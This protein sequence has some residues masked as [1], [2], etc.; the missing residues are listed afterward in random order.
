MSIILPDSIKTAL[1]I[2]SEGGFEAYTVGGAVRD[3]LLGTAP[4]DWDITTSALPEDIRRLFSGYRQLLF[5]M[6]H[7]TVSV[8]IDTSPI[9]ITTYRLDGDYS[10]SRH[11][12]C[13]VFTDKLS[14]DVSRRDFTVNALC[15]DFNGEIRDEAGGLADIKNRII[16]TVGNPDKRFSEDALRILRGMRFSSVLGFGIE[17]K[18]ARS[19]HINRHLLKD[20]SAERVYSELIKLICGKDALRVLLEYGDVLA[21]VIPDIEPAIGFEQHGKKHC[22]NVWEHICHTVDNIE[23]DS[24]LRLTMLLHDLGKVPTAAIDENGSSTFK[25]HAAVGAQIAEKALREL[26]AQTKTIKAVTKLIAAHDFEIPQTLPAVRHML[27]DVGEEDLRR[28]LLIK[29]ADRGALSPEYRDVSAQCAAARE[30]IDRVISQKLCFSL[31]T[32]ALKGNHL[33]ELSIPED[34]I[35]KALDMLLDAVIDEKCENTKK[36]LCEYLKLNIEPIEY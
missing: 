16:R 26:R 29:T 15:C 21:V 12:D 11:P 10:D 2:L 13:V 34:R 30:L 35:G 33:A 20:I 8:I 28:L 14:E 1:R 22:Y 5:G 19:I 17:E 4:G 3:S 23:N 32:L 25:N 7:G 27:K 6:K 9:E 31:S 24:L 36:A 18:T